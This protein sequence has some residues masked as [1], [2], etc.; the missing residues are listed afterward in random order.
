MDTIILGYYNEKLKLTDFECLVR[1]LSK[2]K[3]R[4]FESK[5]PFSPVD[6]KNTPD[7]YDM[8]KRKEG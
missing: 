2:A 7:Q 3:K 8:L 6:V 4:S 5:A 1:G